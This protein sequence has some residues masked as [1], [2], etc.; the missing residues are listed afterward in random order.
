[1]GATPIFDLQELQNVLGPGK[2]V[3]EGAK[4]MRKQIVGVFAAIVVLSG[5]A[6][7]APEPV[8]GDLVVDEAKVAA[9]ESSARANGV[10]VIWM[11]MPVKRLEATGK[12]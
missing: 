7:V 9:I 10:R 5:C 3:S 12:S 2:A 1:L 11:H 6:A 4:S 8:V